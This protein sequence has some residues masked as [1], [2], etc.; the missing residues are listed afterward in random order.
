MSRSRDSRRSSSVLVASMSTKARPRSIM[1]Q[2]RRA[3]CSSAGGFARRFD[4]FGRWAWIGR[5]PVDPA[6]GDGVPEGGR[7]GGVDTLDGAGGRGLAPVRLAARLRAV[8]GGPRSGARRAGRRRARCSGAGGCRTGPGRRPGARAC[9]ASSPPAPGSGCVAR[10]RPS[11]HG[12][13]R[14]G[15]PPASRLPGA[16][17]RWPTSQER[18]SSPVGGVAWASAA[19]DSAAAAGSLASVTARPITRM[20]APLRMAS[21]GV[22]TRA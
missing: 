8:V 2:R 15:R 4:S 14:R 17:T 7:Q 10:T 3:T 18:K 1:S 13:W 6:P 9:A 19:M 22:A 5:V 20:S 11:S 21:V 12:C 16:W